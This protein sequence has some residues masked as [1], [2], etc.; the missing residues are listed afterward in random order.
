MMNKKKSDFIESMSGQVVSFKQIDPIQNKKTL[1]FYI[2]PW[3]TEDNV[4]R[5]LSIMREDGKIGSMNIMWVNIPTA[6]IFPIEERI[7]WLLE[8]ELNV[9]KHEKI[10]R[11]NYKE[12]ID[13]IF[14]QCN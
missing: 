7:L 2:F 12:T 10:I 8:H 11:M 5:N 9:K 6:I 4:P 14:D 1:T 13:G 3:D